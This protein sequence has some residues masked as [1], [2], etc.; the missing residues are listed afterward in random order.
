M[1][2]NKK[3]H[4]EGLVARLAK[5]I[6]S[7]PWEESDKHPV[8]RKE[9]IDKRIDA[10]EER[11]GR[12]PQSYREF[13]QLANGMEGV[14]APDW[15][16][17]GTSE[18]RVGMKY[19]TFERKF[20]SPAADVIVDELSPNE[21]DSYLIGGN[22]E[23]VAAFLKRQKDGSFAEEVGLY[24][25]PIL[26]SPDHVF[27]NFT[28]FVEFV[29]YTY[30]VK[31]GT[32]SK[33]L[34]D[35]YESLYLILD[36]PEDDPDKF[37]FGPNQFGEHY[38]D[39]VVDVYE[40]D[41]IGDSDDLD[42]DLDDERELERKQRLQISAILDKNP[43]L[44]DALEILSSV[45][46][47]EEDE[48]EYEEEEEYEEESAPQ[49]SDKMQLAASVVDKAVKRLLD[50]E[51]LELAEEPLSARSNLEDAMLTSLLESRNRRQAVAE[52]FE[53]LTTAREV[54]DLYGTDSEVEDLLHSV[55][56][57][58]DKQL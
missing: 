40:A 35:K 36:E 48:D 15:S 51:L 55:F 8:L 57:E 34:S 19:K 7:I 22:F 39:V 58:V 38:D 13:L 4:M 24:Q 26:V 37:D 6:D 14:Y 47:E 11:E 54:E 20:F 3:S 5:V 18:V 53:I 32:P 2:D 52:W 9:Q 49:L 16:V 44:G 10:F 56:D 21:E 31:A 28:E 41:S 43:L 1:S 27:P 45:R 12:L 42:D 29:L 17:R 25:L 46:E 33:D 50:E 23:G 30:E